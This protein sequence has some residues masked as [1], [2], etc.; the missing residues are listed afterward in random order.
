MK[1]IFLAFLLLVLAPSTPADSAAVITLIDAAVQSPPVASEEGVRVVVEARGA[2]QAVLCPAGRVADHCA[3][4]RPGDIVG[5]IA[6]LPAADVDGAP[7][8]TVTGLLIKPEAS[9]PGEP[10]DDSDGD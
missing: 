10:P 2:V 9:P 7:L 3:I 8:P 5:L 1:Q 4:L 6:D